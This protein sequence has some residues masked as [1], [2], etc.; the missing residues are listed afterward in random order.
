[1]ETPAVRGNRRA[2]WVAVCPFR[3][4]RDPVPDDRTAEDERKDLFT[5]LPKTACI[6]AA[7]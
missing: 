6:L 3:K 4:A 1:M 7:T 5:C 2:G